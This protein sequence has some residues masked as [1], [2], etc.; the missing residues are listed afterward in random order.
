METKF[1]RTAVGQTVPELV[2]TQPQAAQRTQI[3]LE[4][5]TVTLAI[6]ARVSLAST[7]LRM[8][9]KPM[10]IAEVPVELVK[11]GINAILQVTAR[12]RATLAVTVVV[13]MSTTIY[14]ASRTSQK[15]L[16][17]NIAPLATTA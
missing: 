5:V 16:G 12:P 14:D 6:R 7:I 8:V 9:T 15:A 11:M 3:V 2:P 1:A 17:T 10:R 4:L 13:I